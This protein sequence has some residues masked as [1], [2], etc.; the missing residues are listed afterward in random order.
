MSGVAGANVCILLIA[1]CIL[2][3]LSYHGIEHELGVVY[4]C[5]KFQPKCGPSLACSVLHC[6]RIE[7]KDG[8]RHVIARKGLSVDALFIAAAALV[9][10][11]LPCTDRDIYCTAA[12]IADITAIS[13]RKNLTV[14]ELQHCRRK[15]APRTHEMLIHKLDPISLP[16]RADRSE[17]RAV[18]GSDL[19]VK[20]AI[21]CARRPKF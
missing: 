1:E 10:I 4:Y 6:T 9:R 16:P 12:T 15:L 20:K 14:R 5:R 18:P 7:A 13:I 2:C 19:D 3:G 21:Q 11:P 8:R 17:S